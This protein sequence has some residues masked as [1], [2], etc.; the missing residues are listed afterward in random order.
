MSIGRKGYT[1][2][3]A[4]NMRFL[5]DHIGIAEI[6]KTDNYAKL[7]DGE[8]RAL[9]EIVRQRGGWNAIQKVAI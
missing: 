7:T 5:A 8:R 1:E 2:T 4:A 6:K 9:E 3:D